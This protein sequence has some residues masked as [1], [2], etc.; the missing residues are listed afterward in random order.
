ML[1]LRAKADRG[2]GVAPVYAMIPQDFRFSDTLKSFL[3][4]SLK[5]FEWIM[6]GN[7]SLPLAN[8]A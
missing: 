2:C 4:Q 5:S 8:I 1:T 3:Q 6:R 7:R